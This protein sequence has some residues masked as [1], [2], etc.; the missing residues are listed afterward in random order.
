M[1]TETPLATYRLQLSASFGFEQAADLVP[2]LKSFGI[3]H[4]YASPFLKARKGST[5]GYDIV[6]HGQLNPEFGGQKGF[7]ILSAAL[8]A[9]DMGLILDFV[10]NHMGV[11]YSDNVWWLDVLEWGQKSPYAESFDIDWDTLPYRRGGGLLIPILGRPYGEALEHG[12]ITLRYDPDEGSFS[13]W[14]FEHR[15]PIR[16]NRYD[17]IVRTAVTAAQA[18]ETPAG[19]RLLEVTSAYSDPALPTREQAPDLKHALRSVEGGA[20]IIR[21][22]LH[23]YNDDVTSARGLLHRLLERQHYRVAHWRVAISEVNYR[24][25]FDITD[26]AGIRVEHSHTFGYV[27]RLTFELIKQGVLH[28]LRFDHID[29]LRDPIRYFARLRPLVRT[30]E[31]RT[32]LVV[33]K[34]LAEN[35]T[36]P[37]LAGVSGTTGYDV[38]NLITRVL[39]DDAGVPALDETLRDVVPKGTDFSSILKLAKIRVLETMLASEFTVLTRLLARIAAGH[40]PSRD[41]TSDRLRAALQLYIVHFPKYRTYISRGKVPKDDLET[42]RRTIEAAR[43]D[44]FGPDVAI[45]DFLQDALTLKLIAPDRAGYSKPKVTRFAGKLQQLTGPVMAKAMEDTSFYRYHRLLALNEVGNEPDLPGL[46]LGEFHTRMTA[47][48]ISQPHSMVAT[49]THDTKRGEDARMRILALAELAPLW[50]DAVQRWTSLNKGLIA[51]GSERAPSPGHE[52]MLY[53]ALIGSWPLDRPNQE[54]LQRM[55][56]YAVKA[57]REGKQETNWANPNETY[58]TGLTQ[59]L[60]HILNPAESAEFIREFGEFARRTALIGALNGLSQTVLKAMLPGV[61][62][63]YQ[64]TEFWDLSLVDPDNRRPV[65]FSSRA[66]ALAKFSAGADWS[67]LAAS[68]P[69]GRIKAALIHRLLQ[70][71]GEFPNVFLNGRYERIEVTGPHRD[72]IVAFARIGR[73]NAVLVAVA[74]HFASF[75]ENGQRWP[76]AAAWDAA[77]DVARFNILEDGLRR[78]PFRSAE[79][80][81]G[82]LFGVMPVA[83]LR[84]TVRR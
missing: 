50:R 11:G 59:F 75:T 39:L 23:A 40:F 67:S 12:E 21:S 41:Y 17:D 57:A 58:E 32:Y 52:Y 56:A 31:R 20:D 7:D 6:D 27:H 69:D 68:W 44:W 33:E 42:I 55:Q 25:F 65:D 74:R 34:I 35:E 19:R 70:L 28:G 78:E 48:A 15:L 10:P 8:T 47:R 13:A 4:L 60:E 66:E 18:G 53:Q 71:R 49:A 3:S 5:H 37:R 2:Y 82:A 76:D 79:V 16:P 80:S 83:V 22:G 84:A 72:N 45:F 1:P 64:G 51:S 63:F 30:P 73:R 77:L 29:G 54:F 62:D 9:A 61:P 36:M 38:L 24:R 46:D 81:A 14:Y 43:K 26:L